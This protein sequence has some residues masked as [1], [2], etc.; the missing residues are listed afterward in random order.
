MQPAHKMSPG[1]A[2]ALLI[3]AALSTVLAGLPLAHAAASFKVSTSV[4]RDET[5]NN[6]QV[7]ETAYQSSESKNIPSTS[8]HDRVGV[9]HEDCNNALCPREQSMGYPFPSRSL[10]FP[11][12]M[13]ASGIILPSRIRL[14]NFSL[15]TQSIGDVETAVGVVMNDVSAYVRLRC[16]GMRTIRLKRTAASVARGE[17]IALIYNWKLR[18][19]IN[20]GAWSSPDGV[21]TF[22]PNQV[23]QAISATGQFTDLRVFIHPDRVGEILFEEFLCCGTCAVP[24][25]DFEPL[26]PPP[27]PPTAECDCSAQAGSTCPSVQASSGS[28][29]LRVYLAL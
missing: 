29:R 17:T 28:V 16:S 13:P 23:A 3:V 15:V 4:V 19:D 18:D 2:F 10:P 27:P 14:T 1:G 25:G 12:T 8:R 6:M 20:G 21:A 11:D 5:A 26:P 7:T 9:K 24:M 22:A